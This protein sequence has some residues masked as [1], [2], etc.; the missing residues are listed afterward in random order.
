MRRMIVGI[1]QGKL[2]EALGITFQ[3]VHKYEKGT[4]RIGAGRLQLIALVLGVPIEFFFKGVPHASRRGAF[5]SDAGLGHATSFLSTS[6]GV[7]LMHAFMRVADPKI[8]R[9]FLS[10]VKAMAE[11]NSV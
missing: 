8:R 5:A 9:R 6:E 3:Q 4:N 11:S 1:S 2:G 10:F 7:Q